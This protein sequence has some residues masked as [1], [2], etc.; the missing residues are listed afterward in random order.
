MP[1]AGAKPPGGNFYPADATREEV[2][3]WM[4]SLPDAQH[5]AATGF[6]TTIRRT[7]DGKLTAVPYSLEYQGELA[8]MARLL[9][10]AAALTKQ[11][12]LKSFLEKR[13]DAFVSNDYYAS[14]VAWMELDA[15]IEPTIGPYE[16][17]ED[18]WFNFKAAFE[19]FITLTDARRDA[20]AR[21][22]QQRA[23]GPGEPPADR[24]SS[25]AAAEAR[26]LLADPRRQRRVRGRRRQPR[27][28]DR[29]LQ[30]AER[31]ARRRREG[32][33][34]RA[35]EE[36]PAG[37][38]REGAGADREAVRSRRRT[39]ALV[40]F[41]P[42][43]THILM[44]ELMHGLGPQTIRV[45]GRE[46]T[47]RQELKELN[48][49]LEEAK[50]DISGLWALQYLMDKGV[51]DKKQERSMY[52]TF[53]AS[54]F[55][56]LRFGLNDA[57]AK[58]MALQVNYLLDHG[59]IRIDK[60][61]LFSLDLREDEEGGRRTDARHHDAAGARRLRRREAAARAHGRD[62]PGGA[63]RDRPARER[64]RRHRAEVR[65]GGRADAG[66]M[67]AMRIDRRDFTRLSG[68]AVRRGARAGL[69]QSLCEAWRAR[70]CTD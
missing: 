41:D 54:T 13:A 30:P 63:A 58:G 53:L 19:S 1:G 47:V 20:Q 18:E 46:T 25:S 62:P 24:S 50:A 33:E 14:D 22:L 21:A 10:E 48:G 6:F 38:V 55:R 15:S 70:K 69:R 29:R 27:R 23:A 36:L 64:A 66:G 26:R 57:H 34:A 68:A 28:A 65:H 37:E 31:R 60:D 39:S 2:D 12:T 56:T 8:E 5:A 59:A 61:G 43:F 49:P 9:R 45:G 16:V 67:S 3:A 51:I 4:K 35:A 17:Y 7:P 42:F 44:H 52:V 40:A 32:L 11:P